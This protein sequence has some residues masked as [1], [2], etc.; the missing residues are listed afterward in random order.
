MLHKI[1]NYFNRDFI[2][3]TEALEYYFDNK[4]P[5]WFALLYYILMI[6]V[7]IIL[8]PFVLIWFVVVIIQLVISNLKLGR[9]I[10]DTFKR[11]E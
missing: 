10:K 6:P 11:A 5:M 3:V 9:S 4:L 2:S 1:I 7:A 8:L